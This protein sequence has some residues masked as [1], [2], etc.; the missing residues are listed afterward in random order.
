MDFSAT[1]IDTLA[2]IIALLLWTLEGFIT[3]SDI[4]LTDY[5]CRGVLP[6]MDVCFSQNL[7]SLSV[8]VPSGLSQTVNPTGA[9]QVSFLIV[10]ASSRQ[11]WESGD[12][13]LL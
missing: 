5:S 11:V 3:K 2:E 12:E 9:G 10:P 1:A 7:S 13:V 4:P 8:W 6:K